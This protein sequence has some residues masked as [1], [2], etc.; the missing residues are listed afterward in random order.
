MAENPQ[1]WSYQLAYSSALSDLNIIRLY[2]ILMGHCQ[3]FAYK[4]IYVY[5]PF[6]LKTS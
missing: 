1:N 5:F 6:V 4:C 2:N 3:V